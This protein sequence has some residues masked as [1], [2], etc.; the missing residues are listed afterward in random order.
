MMSR[1]R[2]AQRILDKLRERRATLQAALDELFSSGV[3]SA[4]LGSAGNSQSYTRLSPDQYRAEIARIDRQIATLLRGGSV[5][6][7]SPNILNG[8]AYGHA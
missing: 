6:R 7:T 2:N 8:G 3:S 4:S 5:R 1:S